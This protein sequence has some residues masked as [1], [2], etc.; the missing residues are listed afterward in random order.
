VLGYDA[1]IQGFLRFRTIFEEVK[2]LPQEG[3]RSLWITAFESLRR[4]RFAVVE[5]IRAIHSFFM[6]RERM[7]LRALNTAKS[8]YR[9]AHILRRKHYITAAEGWKNGYHILIQQDEH[10]R[11]YYCLG[12]TTLTLLPPSE[13]SRPL[14]P[15]TAPLSLTFFPSP[16]T[17]PIAFLALSSSCFLMN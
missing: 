1:D 4:L 16:L 3:C 5:Q 9:R 17:L 14:A 11:H 15:L 6:A 13:P 8:D 12:S 2:Y 7:D 10:P